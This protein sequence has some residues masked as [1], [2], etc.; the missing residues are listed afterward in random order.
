MGYFSEMYRQARKNLGFNDIVLELKNIE[1]K[2][3]L[4]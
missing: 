4:S 1:P 3:I 2:G